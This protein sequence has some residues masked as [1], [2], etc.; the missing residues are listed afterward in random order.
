VSRANG[1]SCG[2]RAGDSAAGPDTLS[3]AVP[4]GSAF[5]G[6]SADLQSA[7]WDRWPVLAAYTA[8][9]DELRPRIVEALTS[10]RAAADDLTV[11]IVL[12]IV[13]PAAH[14]ADLVAAALV[15]SRVCTAW[16]GEELPRRGRD[17][18]GL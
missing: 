18:V 7:G 1:G 15:Q 9:G 2:R 3:A 13:L 10:V 12:A 6:I 14:V 8:V 16:A 11:V 17:H 5:G 4:D